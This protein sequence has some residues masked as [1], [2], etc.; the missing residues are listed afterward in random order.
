MFH[1]KVFTCFL[2][3]IKRLVPIF[4]KLTIFKALKARNTKYHI[5]VSFEANFFKIYKAGISSPWMILKLWDWDK[6]YRSILKEN[7]YLIWKC[8]TNW[9]LSSTLALPWFCANSFRFH[10]NCYSLLPIGIPN[11]VKQEFSKNCKVK[12]ISAC[13]SQFSIKFR[14]LFSMQIKK[15]CMVWSWNFRKEL[16]TNFFLCIV[17]RIIIERHC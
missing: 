2:F 3:S 12:W 16:S 17:E 15:F 4:L 9:H 1:C 5:F 13:E 10:I 8:E 14:S 7:T 11:F 6:E